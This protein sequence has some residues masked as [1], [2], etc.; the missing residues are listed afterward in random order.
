MTQDHYLIVAELIF[1]SHEGAAALCVE[2]EYGKETRRDKCATQPFGIIDS[3]KVEP[4][5]GVSGDLIERFALL[6][7]VRK[8][9]RRNFSRIQTGRMEIAPDNH[10]PSRV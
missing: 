6:F 9:R 1:F 3:R 2:A 4:L 10:E 5:C 7:E 8:L